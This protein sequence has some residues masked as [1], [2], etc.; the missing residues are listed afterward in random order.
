MAKAYVWDAATI[1]S[2]GLDPTFLTICRD[3]PCE[4]AK[5]D[6]CTAKGWCVETRMRR[7]ATLA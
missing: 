4:A 1:R 3:K 6:S 2:V 7:N 5:R